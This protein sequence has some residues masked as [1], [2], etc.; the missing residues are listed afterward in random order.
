MAKALTDDELRTL[1]DTELRQCYG[2]GSGKLEQERRR[3]EYFFL[4]EAK[5]ELAPPAIEGRSRVVDT[6]VRDTVLG[7]EGPLLRTFYGSDNVFEFEE[8]VPGDE[9]KAKLISEYVNHVFRKKNPGYTIAATWIREALSQKV[10]VIKVWWDDSDIESRE[11]FFGQTIE[12][13]TL[14]MDDPELSLIEQ[15]AYPDEDAAKQQQ[16][17][18]Q[19]MEQ[20]LAQMA[21]AAETNPQAA[22]Q[23][24]GAQ[25]QYAQAKALPVPMLYDVSFKRTKKGG[26]LCIENV[27]PEEFLISKRAKSIKTSPFTAHRFK[28]TVAQLKTSGYTIPDPLPSDDAGAQF[29]QERVERMNSLDYDT[30]ALDLNSSSSDPSQREVWVVESYLQVDRDG[31]GIPEW[32]K[33]VKCGTA[34]LDDVEFDE[35]PFVA[36]G[37][38]LMPYLLYGL[39]PADLA[40]EPQKIKTSLKRSLLDNQYNQVNGRT[41]ALE[42]Q[43]NLDDLLNN[44]PGGVVRVK[45]PDAVGPLQQGMGDLAGAMNLAEYFDRETEEA[46]G[47][48]RHSQGGSSEILG[49]N[50][51]DQANI[52]TNRA[53]MRTESIA[54]YMAETGFRELGLMILKLVCKYQRK[55]EMVKI[56]GQWVN[57]DPREWT[58]QFSLEVNVGL[59]TGNK[60]QLIQHLMAL[61]QKQ[62]EALQLGCATPQNIYAANKR[63]SSALGFKNGDEFFTDP[64]KMPPKPPQQD[65]AIVKAQLDDQ[66]HQ[67]EMALKAQQ[68]Q[69]DAENARYKAQVDAE[70]QMRIDANRQQA[71]DAKHQREMEYQAQLKALEQQYQDQQAAR[72]D[73]RERYRID[74]DN[75]TKIVVAQ[76][77]AKAKE[78]A[79]LAA[80][81]TDAAQDVT[82]DGNG[83][84]A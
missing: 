27:P 54:R 80:A 16:S 71:E 32:R 56:G 72:D 23:L 1:I 10:G 58:N 61:G 76:I 49:T 81:E 17:M 46:T 62:V 73:A 51:A 82:G 20:Q 14:L 60:G 57:I 83:Q 25:A 64:A 35:P 43:V 45:R 12:Q 31:D 48:T 40:I 74:Q 67:R 30:Y 42:G 77:A 38:I 39:C 65:P 26:R 13:V 79:A 33:V 70:A 52:V 75:A 28:R 24:Q 15:K 44:R 59:G 29:S 9:P 8:T 19:Q 4:A 3:A 53:D 41:F 47:Y 55:A 11:D 6:T 50:T 63:L 18:L 69:M 2:Y 37:S 21:Q 78:S 34:I 68:T 66:A 5:E 7:L 22:Q 84:D 36:L